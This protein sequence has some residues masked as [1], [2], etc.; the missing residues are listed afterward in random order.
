[1]RKDIG[2]RRGQTGKEMDEKRVRK[3]CDEGCKEARSVNKLDVAA[4][5]AAAPAAATDTRKYHSQATLIETYSRS[6]A[7]EQPLC[8]IIISVC[9]YV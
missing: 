4:A 1:M 5:A 2:G 8:E 7:P 9:I 3:E 6:P